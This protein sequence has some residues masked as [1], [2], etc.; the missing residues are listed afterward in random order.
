MGGGS[1]T[2][3][4][5]Y[6]GASAHAATMLHAGQRL[7][8]PDE[9]ESGRLTERWGKCNS[10]EATKVR[11]RGDAL[12]A[13]RRSAALRRAQR[14][15]TGV[16]VVW[17]RRAHAHKQRVSKWPSSRTC[18]DGGLNADVG[19]A[20]GLSGCMAAGLALL[21]EQYVSCSRST[22][23]V[24][25]ITHEYISVVSV[26]GDVRNTKSVHYRSVLPTYSSSGNHYAL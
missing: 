21:E 4:R 10:T 23:V 13:A 7:A 1:L 22:G 6:G 26:A 16:S 15:T 20:V 24:Y 3:H 25:L 11:V 17:R 5:G 8:R 14:T 18:E 9:S 2:A 12:N 19:N